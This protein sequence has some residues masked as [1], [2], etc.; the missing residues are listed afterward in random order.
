MERRYRDLESQVQVYEK[1]LRRVQFRVSPEDGDL[2]ARTLAHYSETSDMKGTVTDRGQSQTIGDGAVY[3][4]ECVQE[5][6]HSSKT[7]QPIGFI[8]G[9]SELSWI[10]DLNQEV[11]K[12]TISSDG[13]SPN[14]VPTNDSEVLSRV[15][16]FLDDQELAIYGNIDLQIQPPQGVA[17]RLLC[18]YFQTVHL[19]F[20]IISKLSFTQQVG[21]YYANPNLRPPKKWLAILNLVFAAAA[22]FAHLVPQHLMQSMDS[23]TEYF[24][25]AQQLATAENP[26]IE[27]PN[28]QQVQIEG[29]TAFLCMVLG[30]INRSRRVCGIAIRSSIAMGINLRNQS[31][32]I[33]NTS[34]EIRY[35]VW[36]SLYTLENTLSVMT[37]RPTGTSDRFCTT[38]LPIPFEEE[39][40][41]QDPA[42]RL[43]ADSGFRAEY[44]RDF[45]FFGCTPAN[46]PP[47]TDKIGGRRPDSK[48]QDIVP[49]TSRY[50]LYFVELTKIMRQA[51]DSLYSP[52]FARRPWLTIYA[53]MI[54]LV[55]ETD[56]W[57]SGLAAAFSFKD[58]QGSGQ[59]DRWRWGLAVRFHSVRITICRPS[60]CRSGRHRQGTEPSKDLQ[61]TADI[62]IDSACQLLDLLPDKPDGIWLAQVSP[63]WCVLHYLMQS[64]TILLIE[65]GYRI[66]TGADQAAF[67]ESRI[68]K[69]LD[70]LSTLAA[71]DLAAERAFR[72]CDSLHR[73]LLLR[74]IIE[75]DRVPR[76][77]AALSTKLTPSDDVPNLVSQAEHNFTHVSVMPHRTGESAFMDSEMRNETMFHPALQ[78]PYDEFMPYNLDSAWN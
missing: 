48:F 7:L 47:N 59:F 78:T 66:G 62:C 65:L 70:W 5:D 17:E 50:F 51:V 4:I 69:A 31:K 43:L 76:F 2:I 67:V 58:H 77:S 61:E 68:K 55:H 6:L 64:A 52:G 36:W 45:T 18:L 30:H 8:G 72:V 13:I 63:W 24:F 19:S 25:R 75:Q 37:G 3:A 14:E 20:P 39:Q 23:P 73:R 44:M 38:P 46:R 12:Y 40:F 33:S 54:D 32:E 9:P 42:V 27:H 60:L 26:L 22:K 1:L 41:H 28:L 16:Y 11:E 57:L 74:S 15:S 71:D 10:Q 56:E 49:N 34:R 35:R 53:A 29:L 21:R